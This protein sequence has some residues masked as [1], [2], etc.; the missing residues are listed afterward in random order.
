MSISEQATL[1]DRPSENAA[2]PLRVACIDAGSNAIRFVAA[3]FTSPSQSRVLSVDRAP[4]RLGHGVFLN[5]RLGVRAGEAA[6]SALAIFAERIRDL[7]VQRYRAVATSAVR[8]SA[9]G[10]EFIGRVRKETGIDLEVINGS[11][12][13]RLVHLAVRNRIPLGTV[14]WFAVDLGGGSVEVSLIDDSGILWSESHTMGSVRLLEEL[15]GAGDDPGRFRRI[16]SEYISTLGVPP[17][18]RE[19]TLAGFIATGGNSDTLAELA[20]CAPDAGGVRVL[21]LTELRRTIET[22]S[23]LSYRERVE[24]LGLRVDRADVVLP[25][26]LVYERLAALV[27]AERLHIPAVGVKEGVLID[28]VDDL[29]E[30]RSHEERQE[31]EVFTASVNLGRRYLFDEAHARHVT[32]L[33]RSLFDQ[34]ADVHRLDGSDRRILTA[35]GILH[36]I[37]SFVSRKR[38]HHHSQYLVAHSELAGLSPNEI[39]LAAHVA[40]YHR[41]SG[42]SSVHAGY[43]Q[44]PGSDRERIDKLSALLRLADALDR[45]HR[46][47]VKGVR[48]RLAKGEATLVAETEDDLLLERMTLKKRAQLFTKL[49]GLKVRLEAERVS[50]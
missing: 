25:A 20:G 8:E 7:K 32:G 37:G 43:A 28:L 31:T 5:G 36:D 15:S 2:F 1:K 17:A 38:H 12:E 14:P 16:L 42:P 39:I 13:A 27:G 40:R 22:L 19:R 4:V 21:P 6:L 46:Q 9:N 30:H 10:A 18:V 35:A 3:E 11:E 24:T 47:V 49:F 45:E 34:L 23:R 44:L 26:A 50:G 29:T 41:K 33:A 48:V